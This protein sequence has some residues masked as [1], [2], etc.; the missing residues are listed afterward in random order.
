MMIHLHS[1]QVTYG[2]Q[3]IRSVA[4]IVIDEVFLTS[5]AFDKKELDITAP[6]VFG[7]QA[8]T[9]TPTDSESKSHQ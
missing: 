7:S 6:T 8:Y 9:A 2:A 3:E 1:R 5:G 4:V